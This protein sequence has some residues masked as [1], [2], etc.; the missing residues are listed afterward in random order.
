M[1]VLKCVTPA[2]ACPVQRHGA[3]IQEILFLDPA[4]RRGDSL[5]DIQPP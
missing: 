3:G 2:E 4:F 1:P 5:D